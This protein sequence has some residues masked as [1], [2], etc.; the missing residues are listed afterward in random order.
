[1]ANDQKPP[2]ATPKMR[3][4]IS[5]TPKVGASMA[6]ALE[7]ITI[8]DKNNSRVR[9]LIWRE[10]KISRIAEAAAASPGSI[11]ASP[12]RPSLTFSECAIGVSKPIG[13]NSVLIRTKVPKASETTL[14]HRLK[15]EALGWASRELHS[16]IKRS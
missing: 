6:A 2:T 16:V 11:T 7:I 1:M 8:A 3:R 15:A 9:R 12:A 10:I 13:K 5:K 4:P 14:S